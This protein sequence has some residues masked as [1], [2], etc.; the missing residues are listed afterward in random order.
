MRYVTPEAAD[1]FTPVAT[2]DYCDEP[3]FRGH[4]CEKCHRFVCPVCVCVDAE[5]RRI[6]LCPECPGA[7]I[8][9]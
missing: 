3:T 7:A 6:P 2:C 8:P 5:D 1:R 4:V 9:I